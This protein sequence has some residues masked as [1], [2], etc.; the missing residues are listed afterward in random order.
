MVTG[1]I[2]VLLDNGVLSAA[3]LARHVTIKKTLPWGDTHVTAEVAGYAMRDIA[4]ASLLREINAIVTIGRLIRDGQLA[5]YTYSELEFE[6]FRR[7]VPVK[8][9]YALSDCSISRCRAPVDR[10]KFRHTVHLNEYASKGGKK[11]KRRGMHTG[12]FNQIQ[13]LEW[14]LRLDGVAI[15]SIL[16]HANIIG[17]TEFE[18]QSFR[19]I[20]WF[21]FICSRFGSSENLPD[22]FHLWAAERNNIDVFLTMERK[23]PAMVEQIRQSRNETHQI[24]VSVL[25]PW[26]FLESIGITKLDPMPIEPNRFYDFAETHR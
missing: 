2:N 22:A 7:S 13:F 24:N 21:R 11:D 23:L 18:V 9:F 16:S 25:R 15:E 12:N 4:D 20:D 6:A 26:A 10:S 19:S 3:E 5:A 14:L 1:G 17:L 8:A